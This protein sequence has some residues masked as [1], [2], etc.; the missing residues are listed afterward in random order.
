MKKVRPALLILFGKETIVFSF[1]Q[2]SGSRWPLIDSQ[3]EV[4]S[5]LARRSPVSPASG[6]A[7]TPSGWC[8]GT[9]SSSGSSG[10]SSSSAGLVLHS[11]V[12]EWSSADRS[13]GWDLI[14]ASGPPQKQEVAGVSNRLVR[15]NSGAAVTWRQQQQSLLSMLS[16]Y[17]E[18]L[19]FICCH[20]LLHWQD[21]REMFAY[22]NTGEGR[23]GRPQVMHKIL[24]LWKFE[25]QWHLDSKAC[26][27]V[28]VFCA[29]HPKL[30]VKLILK[31][32]CRTSRLFFFGSECFAH[33]HFFGHS[34]E[35]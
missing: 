4:N 34:V 30:K 23:F 1:L 26:F 21:V 29:I 12:G 22:T 10:S 14:Y 18:V 17:F 19:S 3:G 5:Y 11:P 16:L 35:I 32:E 6:W 24:D 15:G 7:D 28:L 8:T 27:N 9:S 13:T 33:F 31:I 20:A 25:L 2:S